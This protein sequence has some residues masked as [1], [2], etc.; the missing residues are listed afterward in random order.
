MNLFSNKLV[1]KFRLVILLEVTKYCISLPIVVLTQ[2][3]KENIQVVRLADDRHV[4]QQHVR[5]KLLQCGGL[6]DRIIE[7]KV[8]IKSYK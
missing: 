6:L 3:Y 2:I 1:S 5:F 7:A 8:H 4:K